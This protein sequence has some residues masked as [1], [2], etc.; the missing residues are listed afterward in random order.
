[1]HRR[2][3]LLRKILA[4]WDRKATR[5]IGGL[6]MLKTL[7]SWYSQEIVGQTFPP[8]IIR[9]HNLLPVSVLWWVLNWWWCRSG[10]TDAGTPHSIVDWF[11]LGHVFLNRVVCYDLLLMVTTHHLIC[12]GHL[13]YHFLPMLS[14]IFDFKSYHFDFNFILLQSNIINNNCLINLFYWSF[15]LLE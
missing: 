11:E 5:V 2:A 6:P 1:M 14:I 13:K 9:R 7:R 3:S 10:D 8:I 12:F 15:K 4:K